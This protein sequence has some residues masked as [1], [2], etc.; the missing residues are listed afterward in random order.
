MRGCLLSRV[1][2]G[3]PA[4]CPRVDCLQLNPAD[5]RSAHCFSA[6]SPYGN[7]RREEEATIIVPMIDVFVQ[8]PAPSRT[9]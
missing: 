2:S 6:A 4:V 8:S 7:C 5:H 3:R 1:V 9:R